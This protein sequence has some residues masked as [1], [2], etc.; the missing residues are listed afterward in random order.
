[1]KSSRVYA[2]LVVRAATTDH[3]EGCASRRTAWLMRWA[4]KLVC[5][6]RGNN[7]ESMA[8]GITGRGRD[9]IRPRAFG[10]S[11]DG[12]Y[13]DFSSLLEEFFVEIGE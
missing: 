7:R 13:I 8:H 10:L 3:D 4:H 2:C 9:D 1:M 6:S 11:I 12:P 5:R